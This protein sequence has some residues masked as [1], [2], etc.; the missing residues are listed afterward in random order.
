[1]NQNEDVVTALAEIIRRVDGSHT[2]GAAALAEALV[3][4]G[5]TLTKEN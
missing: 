2:L 3:E 1:M 5:V 4:N